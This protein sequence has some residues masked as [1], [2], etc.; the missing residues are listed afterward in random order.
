MGTNTDLFLA[1]GQD[2]DLFLADGQAHENDERDR[3]RLSEAE[4]RE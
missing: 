4:G 2:T 3:G 1:D